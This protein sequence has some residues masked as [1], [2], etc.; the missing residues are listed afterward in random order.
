MASLDE[1]SQAYCVIGIL[2]NSERKLVESG[3][4]LS[5][6]ADAAQTAVG[7][8]PFAKA[9]I[10]ACDEESCPNEREND[11]WLTITIE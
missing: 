11:S 4:A 1:T 5:S 3:L 8:G 2:P 6:A 10:D 9:L 7:A